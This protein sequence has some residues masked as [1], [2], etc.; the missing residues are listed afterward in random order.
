MS[1]RFIDTNVLAYLAGSDPRKAE[2]ARTVVAEG[3]TISIQVLNELANVARR[4]MRME[5]AEVADFLGLI[6]P[7]LNLI[8]ITV[9]AHELGLALAEK[10]NLPVYDAMIAASGLRAGCDVLLSED[11]QHGFV[12]AGKMRVENPFRSDGA[13]SGENPDLRCAKL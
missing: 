11:F 3:G 4:K 2:A 6:R 1:V 8:P 10:H 5:W 9:E 12:F 13:E 7:F